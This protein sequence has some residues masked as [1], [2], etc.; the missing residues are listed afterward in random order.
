[1]KMINAL[2]AAMA[3]S[4]TFAFGAGG[5]LAAQPHSRTRLRD[6]PPLLFPRAAARR[7]S[8]GFLDPRC[9]GSNSMT[10]PHSPSHR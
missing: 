2:L 10:F 5:E 6:A 7:A 9:V 8:L 1:M 3:M 4:T